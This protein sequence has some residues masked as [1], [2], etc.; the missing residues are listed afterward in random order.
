MWLIDRKGRRPL[1]LGGIAG[2]GRYADH[3]RI[4]IPHVK[5]FGGNG[6]ACRDQL[7][8][9]CR[10]VCN[11]PGTDFLAVDSEIYPLKIRNSAE[12]IAATLQ[13]GS[14]PSD[15]VNFL[16]L[17]EKVGPSGTFWIYGAS[18]I[19]AGVFSYYY[20]PGNKRAES[21]GD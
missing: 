19:A 20:V 15:H 4:R 7:D 3:A 1:L 10:V 5:P 13:L 17:V 8:G 6:L 21:R 16:T 18:A 12:G 2:M 9:L 11:Q 14:K